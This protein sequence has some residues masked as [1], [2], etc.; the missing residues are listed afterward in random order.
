MEYK[1]KL[2]VENEDYEI[3]YSDWAFSLD[4]LIE[5]SYKA[6]IAIKKVE[7]EVEQKHTIEVDKEF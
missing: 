6:E 1:F 5:K 4:S 3:I 7:A 2:E